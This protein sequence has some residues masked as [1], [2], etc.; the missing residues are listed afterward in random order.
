[1]FYKFLYYRWRLEVIPQNPATQNEIDL[2][3]D[4]VKF[5]DGE[6]MVKGDSI[7]T[8]DNDRVIL[9]SKNSLIEAASN[10]LSSGFDCTFVVA[11]GPNYKQVFIMFLLIGRV[12]WAPCFYGLLPNKS[13]ETYRRLYVLID[14][15]MNAVPKTN[16][17]GEFIKF[18][19]DL[20]VMADFELGERRPWQG[21]HET[22]RM[23]V[24]YFFL[25]LL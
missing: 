2:E 12:Y 25:F 23:K 16:V 15:A 10:S 9:L 14:Q 19:E 6:S 21:L 1:M 7:G 11:P 8:S 20:R 3:C 18:R 24:N 22:H 17:A 4:F 5:S 13:E